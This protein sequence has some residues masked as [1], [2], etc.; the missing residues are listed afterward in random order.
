M[1]EVKEEFLEMESFDSGRFFVSIGIRNKSSNFR[2]EVM[3]VYDPAN[4]EFSKIF[5]EELDSKC[6]RTT[7]PLVMGG[8]FNL[9]RDAGHKNSSNLNFSLMNTFNEFISDNKL[10]EIKRGGARFT[11]TNKQKCPIMVNLDRFLVSTD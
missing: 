11:W 7:L 2:W 5:L 1:L 6:K 9:I 8:D 3:V 4:H 10:F